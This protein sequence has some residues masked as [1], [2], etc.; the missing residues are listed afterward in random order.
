MVDK[1]NTAWWSK[2][3]TTVNFQV[4]KSTTFTFVRFALPFDTLPHFFFFFWPL[5]ISFL[6]LF[7]YAVSVSQISTH[8]HRWF[9][10]A[11]SNFIFPLT[12]KGP[13]RVVKVSCLHFTSFYSLIKCNKTS[14]PLILLSVEREV[15]YHPSVYCQIQCN[16]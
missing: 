10:Q 4:F 1:V 2:F 6:S 14:P 9:L 16:L 15:E 7:K 12:T 13:L 3:F 5:I 11:S 8:Y